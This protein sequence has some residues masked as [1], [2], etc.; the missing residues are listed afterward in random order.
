MPRL[1][2]GVGALLFAAALAASLGAKPSVGIVVD[3]VGRR[4]ESGTTVADLE[5]AGY[6][7]GQPGRM[8]S[9][10]GRVLAR[11]NGVAARVWRNGREVTPARTLYAGDVITSADGRNHVEETVIKRTTIPIP[12]RIVGSGPLIALAAPGSL[13]V[14]QSSIGAVSGEVATSTVVVEPT[15]MIVK[16]YGRTSSQKVVAL[17]F[18]D[19]P[20][21]G[22]TEKV[23]R[24]LRANHVK[25]TFFMVGYLARNY[26]STA[27]KVAA[28]GNGVG[29]H[30]MA[31]R[32]LTTLKAKDV[33]KQISSGERTIKA[34]TGRNAEW[35]R[36]PGG[37]ISQ[38]VW[39]RVRKAGLK[40]ALWDVDPQ[41]WRTTSTS[42]AI[43]R[44]VIANV[45][46]G[47]IVLLHDGGGDRSK[48]IAALPVIIRTLKSKGYRFV[49]LDE[50]P[51]R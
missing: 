5:K 6:L 32:R 12:R 20:W 1:Y 48:T 13:G 33:D 38:P 22:Q 28:Q 27:R 29:N 11:S 45:R 24:V 42:S 25:A 8:V 16:R 14:R 23:L 47:S 18:D 39:A 49:T 51:Q 43:A 46:P 9:L 17:T 44:N 37:H 7:D 40:V 36:P 3:G 35:F 19:G 30:T 41:D 2:L 21:P 50:M 26:R 34:S 31:H 4:V 15:P 10:S